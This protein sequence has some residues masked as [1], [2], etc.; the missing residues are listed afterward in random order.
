VTLRVVETAMLA[1]TAGVASFPSL[2]ALRIEVSVQFFTTP[3]IVKL[4]NDEVQH[5]AAQ[6]RMMQSTLFGE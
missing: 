4:H 1:A 5:Y 3:H 6:C 2:T